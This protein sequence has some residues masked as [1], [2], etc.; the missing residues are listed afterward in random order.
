MAATYRKPLALFSCWCM[1]Y[2]TKK[3]PQKKKKGFQ[4]KEGQ[5]N[6]GAPRAEVAIQDFD[7]VRSLS[8]SRKP[9]FLFGSQSRSARKGAK[10][11]KGKYAEDKLQNLEAEGRDLGRNLLSSAVRDKKKKKD[12]STEADTAP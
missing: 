2:T 11:K 7:R 8:K 5:K 3:V 9:P 6:R 1:N 4:K 12:V 10:G